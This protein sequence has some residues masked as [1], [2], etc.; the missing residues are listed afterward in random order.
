[1]ALTVTVTG[2]VVNSD[3]KTL[4]I[5]RS[6]GGNLLGTVTYTVNILGHVSERTATWTLTTA[7]KSAVTGSLLAGAKAAIAADLG[8]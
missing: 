7:E 2:S 4:H 6:V 8:I 3:V 1:M 5:E